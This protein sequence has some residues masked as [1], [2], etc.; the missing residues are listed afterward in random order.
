[1]EAPKS[2]GRQLSTRLSQLSDGLGEGGLGEGFVQQI[3]IF[4][5]LSGSSA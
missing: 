1:M 3:K 2:L 4:L 5:A